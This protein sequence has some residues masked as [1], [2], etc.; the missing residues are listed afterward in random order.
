MPENEPTGAPA[1][2]G[3]AGQQPTTGDLTNVTNDPASTLNGQPA[4]SQGDT[5]A[6][7]ADVA[8]PAAQKAAQ[9]AAQYRTRLREAEKVIAEFQAEK[10]AREEADLSEL[11]KAQRRLSEYEQERAQLTLQAQERITRAEVRAEAT[12][13]G[14]NPQLAARIV[15]YAAIEYDEQGDPTNVSALLQQAAADYGLTPNAASAI[16]GAPAT[17]AQAPR[18]ASAGMPAAPARSATQGGNGLTREI[19]ERM[20]HREIAARRDEIHEW[21]RTHPNG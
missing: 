5:G 16:P 4:A 19:I 2:S 15:D 20:P 12:R 13:L 7:T 8:N 1:A 6:S 17:P 10:K 18:P 11:E 14:M 21:L 3:A 9:E